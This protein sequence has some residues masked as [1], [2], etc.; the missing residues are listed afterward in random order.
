MR[1]VH[2][3]ENG[4]SEYACKVNEAYMVL[5]ECSYEINKLNKSKESRTGV[6]SIGNII[7]IF[8]GKVITINGVEYSKNNI[9]KT[10]SYVEIEVYIEDKKSGDKYSIMRTLKRNLKDEYNVDIEHRVDSGV[11]EADIRITINGET[12]DVKAQRFIT[13][14][15]FCFEHIVTVNVSTSIK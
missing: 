13:N 11:K 12:K 9:G 6:L 5:K 2:P 3:D 15:I 1:I 4:N 14:S 7:D 10:N 8:N